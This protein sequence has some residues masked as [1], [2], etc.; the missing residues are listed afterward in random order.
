MTT[1]LQYLEA[2][3]IE[4][5]ASQLEGEGYEVI[6]HPTGPDAGYD[7]IAKKNDKKLAI[8]VK[9]SDELRKSAQSIKDLRERAIA[10]GYDEFRLVVVTPPREVTVI[11]EGLEIELYCYLDQN[12]PDELIGRWIP[13]IKFSDVTNV[14]NLEIDFIKLTKEGTHII[15]SGVVK[16]E[17]DADEPHTNSFYAEFPFTFDVKLNHN[18]QITDVYKL[19]VDTSNFSE[20]YL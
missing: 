5:I 13:P 7:L 11:I 1:S 16:V 4:E 12:T 8:E 15:G 19:K 17:M 3:K 18:V 10:G 20:I 9:A 14:S 6:I 2:S